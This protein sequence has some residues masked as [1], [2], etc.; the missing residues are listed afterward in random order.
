MN[1]KIKAEDWEKPT[2][3]NMRVKCKKE[4]IRLKKEI[5]ISNKDKMKSIIKIQDHNKIIAKK[6]TLEISQQESLDKFSNH[7]EDKNQFSEIL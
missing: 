5:K 1:N 3:K 2:M 6:K 7:V 4:K